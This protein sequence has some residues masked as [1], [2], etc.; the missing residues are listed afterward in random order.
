MAEKTSE[1]QAATCRALGIRAEIDLDG[2]ISVRGLVPLGR[3]VPKEPPHHAIRTFRG[4]GCL[5]RRRRS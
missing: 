4:R 2:E 5:V 1:E 3:A